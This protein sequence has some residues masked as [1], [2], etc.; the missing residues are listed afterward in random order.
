MSPARVLSAMNAAD[1]LIE[2]G[3]LTPVYQFVSW[4][5]SAI[6][7]RAESGVAFIPDGTDAADYLFGRKDDLSLENIQSI[8]K[9]I[10]ELVRRLHDADFLHCDL[11]L[12]NFLVTKTSHIYVLDLD[13]SSQ[14]QSRLTHRQCSVNLARLFRS[15]R[16]IGIRHSLELVDIVVDGIERGYGSY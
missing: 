12:M 5:T 3:I 15:V 1:Y 9:K 4:R 11:N 2:K 13:K 6:F 7:T 8:T 16:K 14:P 10:G